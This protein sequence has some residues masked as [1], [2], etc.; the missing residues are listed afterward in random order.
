MSM[1]KQI[2]ELVKTILTLSD[3]QRRTELE[4]KEIRQD[5]HSLAIA[6]HR[7]LLL[8][9][10]IKK[11]RE[12]KVTMDYKLLRVEKYF[13]DPILGDNALRPDLSIS[14]KVCR[15]IRIALNL[16]GYKVPN[17][18]AYDSELQT[19]IFSFQRD[20]NYVPDGYV[21]LDTRHLLTVKLREKLGDQAF[22]SMEY[23]EGEVFP[24]IFL[25]YAHEDVASARRLFEDLREIGVNV[26]F[27][28]ESLLP[29]QKWKVAIEWA[30]SNSRFFLALLSENSVNKK[31]YVQKEVKS[32]LEVLD[33]Y[34]DPAIFIIPVRL[35]AC[36][37]L[38]SSLRDLHWVDMFPHWEDGLERI[39][40]SIAS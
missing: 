6:L 26:W 5:L 15:N 18:D 27:D 11:E 14:K 19:T 24:R 10:Q 23:P 22:N 39:V 9:S 28:N 32:A 30:I 8:P 1:M 20:N 36:N 33:E 38:D 34:P 3:Q 31:G 13:R 17:G 29:G 21:G 40:K 7:G 35:D 2:Y 12:R 25:S 37:P 4:V 16:L